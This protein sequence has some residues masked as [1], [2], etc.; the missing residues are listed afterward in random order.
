MGE[1]KSLSEKQSQKAAPAKKSQ[2]SNNAGEA[3]L[4]DS[5][6]ST[7]QLKKFQEAAQESGRG[8]GLSQLQTKSSNHTGTSR[9]AQLQGLSDTRIASEQSALIQKKENNTGIPDGLKSGMESVSGISLNDVTVHRNSDK[10]AQLQAHAFAQGTDIHLGPGQEKHL[11]H[12]AWHVVQQKQGRVQATTQGNGNVPINDNPSLEKEAT[13]MGQK[14]LKESNSGIPK[15]KN[16]TVSSNAT[17]QLMTNEEFFAAMGDTGKRSF[18]AADAFGAFDDLKNRKESATNFVQSEAEGQIHG[19]MS[20]SKAFAGTGL[21]GGYH[22]MNDGAAGPQGVQIQKEHE[23]HKSN[24]AR[25]ANP[26]EWAASQAIGA[27]SGF[28]SES[29]GA[30][31][32]ALS[33]GMPG[34]GTVAEKGV[35]ALMGMGAD[36]F[37][38]K[39]EKGSNPYSPFYNEEDMADSNEFVG[40]ES[41]SDGFM[42]SLGFGKK[43][44]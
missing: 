19:F 37:K 28:V 29:A 36:F 3:V 10:P 6:S 34:V 25:E 7:F 32:T 40:K 43:K 31:A 20:G 27:A 42:R 16:A 44:K 12:E 30:A 14:A 21:A 17:A 22:K 39:S 24:A 33:G 15:L 2:D 38:G 5:R 11:P 26:L 18:D 4:L 35:S 8:T 23:K 9:V 1:I 41:F 13:Q